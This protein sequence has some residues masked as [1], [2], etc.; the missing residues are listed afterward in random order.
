MF[1]VF[2]S[3][4]NVFCEN[5]AKSSY[6]LNFGQF[7]G[8]FVPADVLRHSYHLKVLGNHWGNAEGALGCYYGNT[9]KST[10]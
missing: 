4:L 6:V 9:K 5:K 8:F 2:L 7:P 10:R 3:F 1:L